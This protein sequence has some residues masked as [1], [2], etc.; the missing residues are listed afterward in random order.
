MIFGFLSEK[1]PFP[2]MVN[3]SIYR[4]SDIKFYKARGRNPS[5]SYIFSTSSRLPTDNAVKFNTW[6][7]ISLL[8]LL[9][10]G[11]FFLPAQD[12]NRSQGAV[13]KTPQWDARRINVMCRK[14]AISI[15]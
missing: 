11:R 15:C 4:F 10:P 1:K 14:I 3:L 12:R 9:L 5:K 2:F 7:S 6:K 13:V 8:L